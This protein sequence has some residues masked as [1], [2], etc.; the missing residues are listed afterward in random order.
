ML[1][2]EEEKAMALI[3]FKVNFNVKYPEEVSGS[4]NEGEYKNWSMIL[5]R[6]GKT[7]SWL[8]DDQGY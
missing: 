3:V 8:I 6:D 1:N 7:S 2:M 4:F 5:I